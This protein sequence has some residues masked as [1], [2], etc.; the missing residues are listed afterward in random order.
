MRNLWN[1]NR[2]TKLLIAATVVAALRMM[3]I[4]AV[5]IGFDVK[6]WPLFA[7]AEVWSGLAY[8][9]LEGVALA[10]VSRRWRRLNPTT[11][12]EWVYWGILAAG[13]LVLLSSIVW[14][15]A[16]AA[17]SVRQGA[18]IDALLSDGGVL[19][20]SMLVAALNPLMVILI[21]IVEDEDDATPPPAP[22]AVQ[23]AWVESIA[24]EWRGPG[25]PPA[26][27]LRSE[28]LAR[29]G[30]ALPLAV[31][32]AVALGW[33]QP[34]DGSG[35]ADSAP[36]L[37][38]V[39]GGEVARL[40]DAVRTAERLGPEHRRLVEALRADGLTW[41]EVASRCE[42]S[43]TTVQRWAKLELNGYQN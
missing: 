29:T 15:T 13:M 24:A 35:V 11:P 18:G 12:V 19:V 7:V 8:A 2:S 33:R 28:Y 10:Y 6:Q 16:L 41:P 5:F 20:W 22:P 21:G 32:D 25:L 14:V 38:D 40:L 42:A 9:V 17:T 4:H 39:A 30:A 37:P 31:A 34:G 1:S 43:E 36:A 26:A 27:W 23:R 3:L